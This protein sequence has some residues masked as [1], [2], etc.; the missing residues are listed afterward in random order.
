MHISPSISEG[1]VR[2]CSFDDEYLILDNFLR[3]PRFSKE[4]VSRWSIRTHITRL[5]KLHQFT[6][7]YMDSRRFSDLRYPPCVIEPFSEFN[8][9]PISSLVINPWSPASG[10]GDKRTSFESLWSEAIVEFQMAG[11]NLYN[12][13]DSWGGTDTGRV[14]QGGTGVVE[15]F[16][17]DLQGLFDL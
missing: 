12:Y 5:A 17:C 11:K 13:A 16:G 10:V 2:R 1:S 3:N 14:G 4:L 7:M 9:A 6:F 15:E 8:K